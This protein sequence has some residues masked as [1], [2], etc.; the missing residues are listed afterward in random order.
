MLFTSEM[1]VD[2]KQLRLSGW[3]SRLLTT[4][5]EHELPFDPQRSR[6]RFCFS[7]IAFRIIRLHFQLILA[8]SKKAFKS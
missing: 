8:S 7:M 3:R 6:L 5:M 4:S 1:S 2:D